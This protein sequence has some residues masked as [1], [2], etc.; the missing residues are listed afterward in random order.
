MMENKE[1]KSFFEK[2]P[3]NKT[4]EKK[5]M[6]VV[7]VLFIIG[8]FVIIVGGI[9][10][11]NSLLPYDSTNSEQIQ[12]KVEDGWGSSVVTD[13]LYEAKLI[14]NATI[15]KLYLKLFPIDKIY[16]GTYNLSQAM[17]VDDIFKKLSS[18][19]SLENE[20]VSLKLI[21]GKRFTDYVDKI[22][23]TFG[24]DKEEVINKSKDKE[25]LN[26]LIDKY[27][28]ITDDILKEGIYYPLEGY[29]FPDTYNIRKNSTIEEV[30]D[31]LINELGNKLAI[32]KTD[33][34]N[35]SKSIH[36]L[37]TL[38]SM[39]ELEAG[40]D[41]TTMDDGTTVY[42]RELVSSVFY[43]RLSS[44][45]KLGSDVTTYYGVN[46]TLQEDISGDLNTCNGYNTR[47]ECVPALPVG[48][49]CSP[50]L[51]S[52]AASIKPATSNYYYFVADKN[53]KLYYAV[54]MEGHNKNISYLKSHDLWA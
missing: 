47:G 6:K 46:K 35:S 50:S 25:Y 30:F 21:E 40:T 7:T 4:I 54:D 22:C 41:K 15:V 12:F 14:K 44:G 8:L 3:D 48:P 49:I 27:W 9:I 31:V 39:I 34:D 18:S 20:T 53:G 10:M 19:D 36:S 28:F 33:I 43:N 1:E 51:S 42:D 32:H 5:A 38:A 45:M 26:T 17:S 37:L 11:A 13:K 2:I 23:E 24:F 16:A 52:I 29:L